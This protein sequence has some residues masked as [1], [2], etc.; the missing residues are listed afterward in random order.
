M[1][2]ST[3]G[4]SNN[5]DEEQR[6]NNTRDTIKNNHGNGSGGGWAQS[7][8]VVGNTRLVELNRGRGV[9]LWSIS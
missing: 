8:A 4:T 7:V 1:A 9:R 5:D 6:S 2:M 3:N